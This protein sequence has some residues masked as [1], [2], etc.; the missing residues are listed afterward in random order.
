MVL[1]QY[2]IMKAIY[3]VM[4]CKTNTKLCPTQLIQNCGHLTKQLHW[5]FLITGLNVLTF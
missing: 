1:C 2:Y 4:S 3:S 5:V